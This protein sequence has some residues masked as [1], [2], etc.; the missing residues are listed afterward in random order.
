MPETCLSASEPPC[1]MQEIPFVF[2]P[3]LELSCM[4]P[5]L[6]GS[7]HW[8]SAGRA[9]RSQCPMRRKSRF[10][11]KHGFSSLRALICFYPQSDDGTGRDAILEHFQKGRMAQ[12]DVAKVGRR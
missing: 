10:R 7:K 4:T 3:S 8:H 12:F 2:F 11:I 9:V 1:S 5:P 6:G